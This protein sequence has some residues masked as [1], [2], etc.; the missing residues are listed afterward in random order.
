[1]KSMTLITAALSGIA[2]IG[3]AS[4]ASNTE[5]I[6]STA[7]NTEGLAKLAADELRTIM[8]DNRL[9]AR[10]ADWTNRCTFKSSGSFECDEGTGGPWS[11]DDSGIMC[12][13]GET[14][15]SGAKGCF[16]AYRKADNGIRFVQ[17]SGGTSRTRTWDAS[18]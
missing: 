11:I 14:I 3:C 18:F 12:Y 10:G 15:N 8:T 9:T 4:T 1:M 16:E 2:L 6:A 7:S 17:V 13:Q 5:G